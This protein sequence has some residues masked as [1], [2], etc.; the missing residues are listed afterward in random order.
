MIVYAEALSTEA[1]Y[2]SDGKPLYCARV[3]PNDSEKY[4]AIQ[5]IMECEAISFS[6]ALHQ[7]LDHALGCEAPLV[8]VTDWTDPREAV[9]LRLE[10]GQEVQEYPELCF[11]A[12]ETNW[13]DLRRSEIEEIFAHELSHLWLHRM[14]YQPALSQSNRFHTSTAITDPFLAFLEGFAEHLEIVSQELLGT[15][16]EGFFDNGYDLGAWLC[17]RD[18]ALRVH[19]VK[20]NRFLYLTAV[21]E[22]EDFASYQQLHMAHITSSA[23]LPE[24]LKN[25]LQ[26]VSSEGLIASFFYQMYR[27]ADLKH[28]PAPAQVY[29][30]FGCDA[31]RLSPAANLYVKILWAMIQL[32][33]RRETLFTDFV[34]KYLEA[35]EADRDIL[36]DIF[37]RVTNF[38]TVDPAAQQMFGEIYRVGRQ[39]DMEKIVRL[40]KQAASQKEIWLAELQ[41]GK[42]RLD[43]AIYKSIWI[44]AGSACSMGFG[45]FD[46]AENQC[47]CRNRRRFL[48]AG[49]SDVS[50]MPRA[51]S[52]PGTVWWFFRLGRVP[53]NRRTDRQQWD[54]PRLTNRSFSPSGG[55]LSCSFR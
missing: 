9:G 31:D 17:S 52:H 5:K 33:W 29:H 35:F 27:S 6:L 49:R 43:D 23:F 19:G 53:P 30:R 1:S 54:E 42:R 8:I 12:L 32:D 4:I 41:S 3:L 55:K 46:P 50:A 15:R 14:G 47:K 51:R 2:T 7:M 13:E 44:E 24:H 22:A 45:A 18:S 28:S 34:Q 36:M 16:K 10:N 25:G 20:N 40:C 37:A 39:G 48:C 21:P 38:V 26:A 11:L